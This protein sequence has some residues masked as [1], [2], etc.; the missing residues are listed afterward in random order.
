MGFRRA[1]AYGQHGGAADTDEQR[2][3]EH[4]DATQ[5]RKA[6]GGAEDLTD[7]NGGNGGLDK[8]E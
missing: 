8:G 6:A 4:G 2:T 5:Q 1:R 7:G 3:E